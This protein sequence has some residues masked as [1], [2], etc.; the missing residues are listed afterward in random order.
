MSVLDDIA[1]VG[2]AETEIG[3]LPGRSAIQLQAEAAVAAVADAGLAKADIDAV[4]SFSGYSQSMMLHAARVAEYLGLRPELAVVADVG[5][6]GTHHAALL[7][8]A[9][10]ID[11]GM[12]TA[13][14]CAYGENGISIRRS[15][16]GRAPGAL[17]GGEDFEAPYGQIAMITG[18][19]LFAQRHMHLYGTTSEQLGAVAVASRHHA[20]LNDNAHK[21]DPI[22]LADHQASPMVSTPLRRLDCSLISDAGGAFVV[23]SLDRART[24]GR[25]F[26]RVLGYGA[27]T[28]HHIASQAPDLD[29]LGGPMAAARAFERAGLSAAEANAVYIHDACTFSVVAGVE[30]LGLCGPGEGGPYAASGALGLGSAHPV[31]L[32][33]GMLSHGHAGGVFHLLDAVR[34]LQ[35]AAGRR[36]VDGAEVAVV[37]GNGG[38]FSAFSTMVL[39]RADP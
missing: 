31:N 7:N 15:G 20:S 19:A 3:K 17:T 16:R 5:G 29:D 33:G 35:G 9:A 4:F 1:I 38:V 18:Y 24:L 32:H 14:L 13:A 8:A 37:H 30:A 23:T 12:C 6:P 25:P 28:T 26:A 39:A 34:Q 21:R 2:V 11:A 36:Q 10:A 27:A 22:T